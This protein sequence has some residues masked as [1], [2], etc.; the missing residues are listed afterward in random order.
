[1]SYTA[2]SDLWE[3]WITFFLKQDWKCS[4]ARSL[5]AGCKMPSPIMLLIQRDKQD[6]QLG[7]FYCISCWE[8]VTA[9]IS[10]VCVANTINREQPGTVLPARL[11]H[12]NFRHPAILKDSKS[13]APASNDPFDY[14]LDGH[15]FLK[16]EHPFL[17]QN[18]KQQPDQQY[19]LV[20]FYFRHS[21]A[22]KL[23]KK[24]KEQML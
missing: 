3:P 21:T 1:M 20:N 4:L 6:E 5:C 14:P 22:R 23:G 16:M 10:Q 8:L 24:N 11:D 9:R 15:P 19:F 2:F 13:F 7:P 12:A 18:E 17:W